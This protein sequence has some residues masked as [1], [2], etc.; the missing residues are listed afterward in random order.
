MESSCVLRN[1]LASLHP[2][3]WKVGISPYAEIPINIQ[4]DEQRR[5]LPHQ[6]SNQLPCNDKRMRSHLPATETPGQGISH[7]RELKSGLSNLLSV[8]ESWSS[9]WGQAWVVAQM[10]GIDPSAFLFH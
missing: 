9:H 5:A 7:W 6:L 2:S 3:T 8:Q 1:T 4:L 10:S